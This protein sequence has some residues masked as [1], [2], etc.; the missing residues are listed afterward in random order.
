V[1][2][3]AMPALRRAALAVAASAVGAYLYL[4]P[5]SGRAPGAAPAAP[6]ADAGASAPAGTFTRRI[7]AVGDLHGD[8]GNA[9]KVLQMAGVVDAERRW[10]GNVD[11]FVQTGD[12]IDRCAR[13]CARRSSHCSSIDVGGVQW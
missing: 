9:H 12:I 5:I 13:A 6:D 8:I 2:H 3:V 1:F 4:Y 10:T 7:V 11:F